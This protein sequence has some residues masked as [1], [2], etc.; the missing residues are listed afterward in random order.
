M[1]GQQGK[2]FMSGSCPCTYLIHYYQIIQKKKSSYQNNNT[3]IEL[4]ILVYSLIRNPPFKCELKDDFTKLYPPTHTH[5]KKK[6]GY[7]K[8]VSLKLLP[9][10][11]IKYFYIFHKKN[12]CTRTYFM[13]FSDYTFVMTLGSY[14]E[15]NIAESQL[16]LFTLI[17]TI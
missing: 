7:K 11:F 13:H 2:D 10:F 17:Y 12:S 14:A 15:K 3:T 1:F 5:K 8:I 9:S 6:T 4:K 16:I